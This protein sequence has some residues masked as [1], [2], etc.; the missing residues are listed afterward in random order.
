MRK[1][2]FTLM[3]VM[4]IMTFIGIVSYADNPVVQTKF[5]ADPAPMV[6]G[7]TVYLYTGH[8]EDDAT[9]FKMKNWLVYSTTDMANWTDRGVGVSLSAFSWADPNNGAWA[10]QCIYRNGKFYWYC[11]VQLKGIGVL[12]SNSPTG[13][14]TDALG[15][16]LI[17]NSSDDIDPTVWVD[18]DGQA[19]MYWGNPNCYYVKLNQDMISYTGGITKISSKPSDYQEGPWL[20]KRNG[21]YYLSYSSTCC[22]EGIGY[23]MSSSPTGPWTWKGK[24]MDPNSISSGNQPGIID[25][26]GTTYCFGFNYYMNLLET[27]THRERRSVCVD[28]M[29]YNTDGTIVKMPWWSTAGPPQ[30]G[31]LN[32]YVQTEAETICWS[33]GVKTEV[34]GEGGI[35]VCNI[36]NGDSIKVKGVNFGTNA[37]SFEARVASANSGGNIE[38]RLDSLTGTLVGT[39]AVTGTGGWQTWVTKTCTISGA[40]GIHDLYFKFTGGSGSLFNFNWWKFSGSGTTP[41]TPTP[42]PTATPDPQSAFSQIEAENFSSMSGVNTETC[43]EGGEDVGF[44]ENG[45]YIAFSNLN[46]GNGAVSFQARVASATSGGSIELRLDSSTGT[47]IGTCPVAGTGDWQTWIT[48]TCNVSGVSNT[49]NLYLVFTGGSGYLFNLSWFKFVP[50]AGPTPTVTQAGIK[51][52]VNGDGKIDIVDALMI[53]QSSVGLTPAGFVT[54][55]ADVNCDGNITIVDALMAAQY[56]VGLL[57]ELKC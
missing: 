12:V 36:E 9:G 55:N 24:I 27:S 51:G 4:L 7:D 56:Y 11:A 2:N 22:P 48:A 19:Y 43:S 35:D 37:T 44:I 47:L 25:Y 57:T 13:P 49:H 1:K 42:L 41:P 32:P 40:T 30:I 46:F 39:C 33:T 3:A 16:P 6:Y 23:A 53:A 5:T 15:K 29:K 50:A 17:N 20:H 34:C 38:I 54:A 8:D 28:I 45:D 52:D 14:F 21:I 10:S 18:D 31:T 26:K